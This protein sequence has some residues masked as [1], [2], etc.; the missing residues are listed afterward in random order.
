MLTNRTVKLY[1]R[2]FGDKKFKKSYF[3]TWKY[4]VFQKIQA[5]TV[6]KTKFAAVPEK[7]R[8]DYL[9]EDTKY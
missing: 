4:F 8:E 9:T 2:K 5:Q 7:E 1:R 6:S 3:E